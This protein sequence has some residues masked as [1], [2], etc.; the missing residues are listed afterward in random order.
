MTPQ[1]KECA[2]RSLL[3]IQSLLC[4]LLIPFMP[5]TASEFSP[6]SEKESII[7]FNPAGIQFDQKTFLHRPYKSSGY[8]S[9]SYIGIWKKAGLPERKAVI[10]LTQLAPGYVYISKYKLEDQITDL[11]KPWTG[12]LT[13]RQKKYAVSSFGGG[14]AQLFK[15]KHLNCVGFQQV[16]GEISGFSMYVEGTETLI[17]YY[18]QSP[19]ELS[20]EQGEAI[21][22]S[23]VVRPHDEPEPEPEPQF[24]DGEEPIND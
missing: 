2:M 6:I 7:E 9:Q 24:D 3:L 18:C 15:I 10:F 17:G 19:D 20:M 22:K 21:A 23:I 5:S 8:E 4:L 14:G 13:F 11:M 12:K 1:G 16:G